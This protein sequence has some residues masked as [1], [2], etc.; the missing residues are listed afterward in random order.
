MCDG[1]SQAAI[2]E[3]TPGLEIPTVNA[4]FCTWKRTTSQTCDLQRCTIRNGNA[5]CT[6]IRTEASDRCRFGSL[7]SFAA[8][9]RPEAPRSEPGA[10]C[11]AIDAPRERPC[12]HYIIVFR[13]AVLR[14][15]ARLDRPIS[16]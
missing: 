11:T 15:L 3:W 13:A 8:W 14:V 5:H 16:S 12:N 7:S 4:A 2:A 9:H 1:A 10:S 6:Y